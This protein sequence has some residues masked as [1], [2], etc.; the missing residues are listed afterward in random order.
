MDKHENFTGKAAIDHFIEMTNINIYFFSLFTFTFGL[1]S[2]WFVSIGS[3]NGL[4]PNIPPI[5]HQTLVTQFA[6]TQCLKVES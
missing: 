5:I 1:N 4:V 3:G 6:R 2:W